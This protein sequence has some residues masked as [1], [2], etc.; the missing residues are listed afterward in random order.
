MLAD[1][2]AL[3]TR[4]GATDEVW[5]YVLDYCAQVSHLFGVVLSA[6]DDLDGGYRCSPIW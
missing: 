5:I 2:N 3:K 4:S 1:L 6:T